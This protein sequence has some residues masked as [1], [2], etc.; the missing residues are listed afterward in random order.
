MLVVLGIPVD[1]KKNLE[2][3]PSF[4]LS[5]TKAVDNK[6]NLEYDTSLAH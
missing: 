2:G 5:S 4:L 1:N 3:Y 6:K